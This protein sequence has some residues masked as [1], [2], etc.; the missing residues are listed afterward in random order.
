MAGFTFRLEPLLKL[1]RTARDERRA[2]LAEAYVAERLLR[3]QVEQ[4]DCQLDEVRNKLRE[5]SQPGTINVAELLGGHRHELML[6]TQK[7]QLADT[8]KKLHEEI[9]RRR[10]L[11]VES[12]KQVRI[13]EKLRERRHESHVTGAAKQDIKASDEFASRRDFSN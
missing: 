6:N 9:E 11:L 5:A 10:E 8:Q 1:R 3:Q 12:D 4:I 7:L 13:L 2:T